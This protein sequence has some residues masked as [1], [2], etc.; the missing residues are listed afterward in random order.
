LLFSA[1][2]FYLCKLYLTVCTYSVLSTPM[3]NHK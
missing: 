2:E 3:F 1:D